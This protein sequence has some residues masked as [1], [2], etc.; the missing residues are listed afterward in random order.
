MNF[1]LCLS[2]FCEIHGPTSIMVTQ[3]LP[4]DLALEH[5]PNGNLRKQQP[6]STVSSHSLRATQSLA[7]MNQSYKRGLSNARPLS[8]SFQKPP[9]S[10][11]YGS[12]DSQHADYSK[13]QPA[14]DKNPRQRANHHMKTYE[15]VS[16]S[17]SSSTFRSGVY[18]N[19]SYQNQFSDFQQTSSPSTHS[20][21]T[22]NKNPLLM[23][24]RPAA[25]SSKSDSLCL[26]CRLTFPIIKVNNNGQQNSNTEG[27]SDEKNAIVTSMRTRKKEPGLGNVVYLS[28]QF[29]QDA[30]KFSILRKVCL[31]MLSSEKS[32]DS[33]PI[34]IS[35]PAQL[36]SSIG[37]VFKV[38]D[39]K[40]RGLFRTYAFICHCDNENLLMHNWVLITRHLIYLKHTIQAQAER[41]Y[42]LDNFKRNQRNDIETEAASRF[43]RQGDS[44]NSTISGA[45]AIASLASRLA[46]EQHNMNFRTDYNTAGGGMYH[47][48]KQLHSPRSLTSITKND[49]FFGELHGQFTYI[50]SLLSKKY[51]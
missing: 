27:K 6:T 14:A 23:S 17:S 46:S 40:A 44:S 10:E 3:S 48:K 22:H 31:K 7:N 4:E 35:D 16:R 50:L 1:M 43:F 51:V 30:D 26:S 36:S 20:D 32:N 29:P 39:A 47:V 2:H 24:G 11:N 42:E 34:M 45:S 38:R 12:R 37:L 41:A 19:N 49:N 21:Q 25:S 28:T 15:S 8:N 18:N 5:I 13:M 33:A 9:T